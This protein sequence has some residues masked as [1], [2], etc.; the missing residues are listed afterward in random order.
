[1]RATRLLSMMALAFMLGACVSKQLPAPPPHFLIS[2]VPPPSD[3][4]ASMAFALPIQVDD[5]RAVQ[6]RTRVGEVYAP[7]G[8]ALPVLGGAGADPAVAAVVAIALFAPTS[9]TGRYL[10]VRDPAEVTLAIERA[11]VSAWLRSGRMASAGIGL[12]AS[13]NSFWIRPSWTMTCELSID[14]RLHD[15]RGAVLWQQEIDGRV[16]AVEG[17]FTTEAFEHVAR[18]AL[19]QFAEK[20]AVAFASPAFAAA[21]AGE[22][23]AP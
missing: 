9:P 8:G 1:M 10:Q 23:G 21:V 2:L 14:L 3:N 13:V 18:M 19:D 7:G 6:D 12:E 20:A 17:A 15:A 22:R 11:L 16:Q 4:G 5:L